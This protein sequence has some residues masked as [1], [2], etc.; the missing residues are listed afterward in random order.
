MTPPHPPHAPPKASGR[1]GPPGSSQGPEQSVTPPLPGQVGADRDPQPTRGRTPPP[2]PPTPTP[3]QR[4]GGCPHQE[5]PLGTE[6]DHHRKMVA[7]WGRQG[8]VCVSPPPSLRPPPPPGACGDP[9]GHS[10]T[11]NPRGRRRRPPHPPSPSRWGPP[12]NGQTSSPLRQ[13]GPPPGSPRPE[14]APHR[15]RLLGAARRRL[16]LR[17]GDGNGDHRPPGRGGEQRGRPRGFAP[18]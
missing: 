6:R 18:P 11:S 3:F 17:R 12:G 4:E 15:V 5:G 8:R 10:G 1:W 2:P 9:R 16:R 14:A 13:K 7:P